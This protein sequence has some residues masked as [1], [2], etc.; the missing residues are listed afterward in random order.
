MTD[1]AVDPPRQPA[2]LDSL[3]DM[4]LP[5]TVEFGRTTMAI[6]EVL[7][8]G[9]GAVV[10]LERMVGEPVDILVGERRFAEGEIVVVGEQFGVRIT[11]LL[12]AAREAGR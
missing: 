9:P 2:G 6:Q 5:V 8:L 4:A 3:L 11:R 7:A 10:S 12:P 1:V